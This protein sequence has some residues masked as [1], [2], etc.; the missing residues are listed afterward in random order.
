MAL[1]EARKETKQAKPFSSKSFYLDLTGFDEIKTLSEDILLLGGSLEQFLSKDVTCVITNRSNKKSAQGNPRYL[2][3]TPD[4]SCRKTPAKL[5]VNKDG[6][7]LQIVSRGIE[8]LKK[9]AK[10]NSGN[11]NVLDN[12]VKWGLEIIQLTEMLAMIEKYK[13]KLALRKQMCKKEAELKSQRVKVL[14]KPYIKFEEV[15]RQTRPAY[16]EFSSWPV[17]VFT[18]DKYLSLNSARSR[19]KS[20][21]VTAAIATAK[22][23]KRFCEICSTPFHGLKTHVTSEQHR[24]SMNGNRRYSIFDSLTDQGYNLDCYLATLSS[25]NARLDHLDETSGV[26]LANYEPDQSLSNFEGECLNDNSI[27]ASE[28]NKNDVKTER[29]VNQE[30]QILSGFTTRRKRSYE[31]TESNSCCNKKSKIDSNSALTIEEIVNELVNALCQTVSLFHPGLESIFHN[32][33]FNRN[34][35]E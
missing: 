27:W 3:D 10:V 20:T 7:N 34:S 6:A 30:E 16:L 31:F 12:A 25:D 28:N 32:V 2:N 9:A 4:T 8:I 19:R 24:K 18:S 17:S 29:Y 5:N 33:T 21:E 14:R 35:D 15:N 26:E 22:S 13:A 23:K 1:E 11:C